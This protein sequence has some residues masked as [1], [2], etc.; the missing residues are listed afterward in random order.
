MLNRSSHKDPLSVMLSTLNLNVD[1]SVNAQFCGNWLI[2]HKT[3]EKSFHLISHGE[4]TLTL[5]E[6]GPQTLYSGDL[7][8]FMRDTPHQM[9]PSMAVKDKASRLD[10]QDGINHMATGILCGSFTYEN[11]KIESLM[12]ALPSLLVIK[13][14]AQSNRWIN[15]L[16]Q[17]I[18]LETVEPSLG[19]DLLIKQ[20]TESLIIQ[21]IRSYIKV[22]NF[23]VG[24]LKLVAD[25]KLAKALQAVQNEP[26]LN[27]TVDL[28]AQ[29][30]A[31]SRT[32]FATHFKQ[33]SN[34]SPMEYVTW[35][36]MQSA[37]SKLT[38]GESIGLVS[39]SVGY[40]SEAAFSRAFKKA[41]DVGPGEVR[42]KK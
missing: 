40:R 41:F 31:M 17:L 29:E 39:E 7:V 35:W 26:Q 19:S 10:Y 8:I 11:T 24:M 9:L 33:I 27:W 36:R 6:T 28:L 2:G 3:E 42:G 14:N 18:Q 20:L 1:I 16:V 37:W 5:Q 23:E 34:W 32:A 12:C 4:C 38:E 21:A 30:C 15:P 13:N 25:N 22:G